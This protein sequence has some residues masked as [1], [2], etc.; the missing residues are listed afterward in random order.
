MT[1]NLLCCAGSKLRK[2]RPLSVEGF[3]A[4]VITHGECD[5]ASLPDSIQGQRQLRQK[6]SRV[7]VCGFSARL[8][9]RSVQ[10]RRRAHHRAPIPLP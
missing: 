6:F 2:N 1:S 9:A 10:H 5:N 3:R 8:R 4:A 7:L